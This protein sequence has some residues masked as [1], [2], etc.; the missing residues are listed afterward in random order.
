MVAT[1]SG[2]G[3]TSLLEYMGSVPTKIGIIAGMFYCVDSQQGAGS[4]G[5]GSGAVPNWIERCPAGRVLRNHT[6]P[7]IAH[8]AP[9]FVIMVLYVFMALAQALLCGLP[10]IKCKACTIRNNDISSSEVLF[11]RIS[12]VGNTSRI[13]R[14][15]A[16]PHC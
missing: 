9:A 6:T 11:F 15:P 2:C 16:D 5:C 3:A 10:Q 13:G 12:S 8:Q 7:V 14:C 4:Q 1:C